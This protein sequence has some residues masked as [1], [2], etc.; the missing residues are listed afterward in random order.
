MLEKNQTDRRREKWRA[1]R[2]VQEMAD[3]TNKAAL[4]Q[5]I[6]SDRLLEVVVLRYGSK[7]QDKD[8]EGS[9]RISSL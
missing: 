2:T 6:W 7:V 8:S 1:L 5:Q 4:G 3:G 9:L